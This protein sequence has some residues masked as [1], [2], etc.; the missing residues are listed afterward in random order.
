M[1]NIKLGETGKERMARIRAA[2]EAF[3]SESIPSILALK[4]EGR[5]AVPCRE[6]AEAR[7]TRLTLVYGMSPDAIG[8]AV[9]SPQGG[10]ILQ[11][12]D[13][14]ERKMIRGEA[15]CKGI[16]T[17]EELLRAA[18]RTGHP[19]NEEDALGI[20]KPPDPQGR[21]PWDGFPA[22]P[23][24]GHVRFTEIMTMPKAAP[25]PQGRDRQGTRMMRIIKG[26][27]RGKGEDKK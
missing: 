21:F 9:Q 26:T 1:S 25:R 20:L 22:D 3:L 27:P 19:L 24:P 10:N 13:R 2:L 15:P 4:D 7:V 16:T 14:L 18:I 23:G 17:V 8:R 12:L 5:S 11:Q 6:R